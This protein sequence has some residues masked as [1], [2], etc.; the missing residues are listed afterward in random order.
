[1]TGRTHPELGLALRQRLART[2]QDKSRRW[3]QSQRDANLYS[4][5]ADTD[6]NTT[7]YVVRRFVLK[8]KGCVPRGV[9]FGILFCDDLPKPTQQTLL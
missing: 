4:E 6:E 9:L 5:R 8:R 1:M 3:E 2:E 7:L